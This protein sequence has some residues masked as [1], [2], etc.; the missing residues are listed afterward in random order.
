M[1]APRSVVITVVMVATV[2][3]M[4]AVVMMAVATMAVGGLCG[5]TRAECGQAENSRQNQAGP[6]AFAEDSSRK[7]DLFLPG[8]LLGSCDPV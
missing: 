3:V 7:H 6:N 5:A 1:D 2:V 8:L 4:M